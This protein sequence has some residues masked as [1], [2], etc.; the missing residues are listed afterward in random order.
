ML[1]LTYF[2]VWHWLV[3][4]FISRRRLLDV[5][6]LTVFVALHRLLTAFIALH[7]LLDA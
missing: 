4:G 3:T 2:I 7:W 6:L 1:L 5:R